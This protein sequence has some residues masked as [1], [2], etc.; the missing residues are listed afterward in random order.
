MPEHNNA[1]PSLTDAV[2][3]LL[4]RTTVQQA[5]VD[6]SLINTTVTVSGWVRTRRDSKGGFSFIQI[7]DGSAFD[8]LQA[9]A[10]QDLPNY[11]SEIQKLTAGCSVSLSGTLVAS[12]GKGQQVELQAERVDVLGWV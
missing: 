7:H 11:S 12:E 9:I 8:S 10:S 3:P 5:L 4:D 2:Q 1:K 6:P